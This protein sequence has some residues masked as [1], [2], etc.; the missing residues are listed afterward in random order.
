[1]FF[2]FALPPAIEGDECRVVEVTRALS[3]R[4]YR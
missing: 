3:V 4:R 1:L 2:R